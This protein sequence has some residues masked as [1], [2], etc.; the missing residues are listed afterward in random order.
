MRISNCELRNET[1]S[2]EA[3]HLLFRN[4]NLK[5]RNPQSAIRE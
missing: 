4:L 3:D 5:F 2:G 1:P